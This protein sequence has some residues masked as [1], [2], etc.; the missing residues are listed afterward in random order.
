MLAWA[1]ENISLP[2]VL[3]ALL[4][5]GPLYQSLRDRVSGPG[6][7]ADGQVDG[8]D[9]DTMSGHVTRTKKGGG[10]M[11]GTWRLVDGDTF[12]D[13]SPDEDG[14]AGSSE[15][16][17]YRLYA[18]DAPELDQTCSDASGAVYACGRAALEQLAALLTAHSPISCE[19]KDNDPYGRALVVCRGQQSA[20]DTTAVD[21][22]GRMVA[23]GHAVS[24]DPMD[25]APPYQQLE[26]RA[27]SAGVGLWSG[28]F[29]MPSAYRRSHRKPNAEEY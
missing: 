11:F 29:E 6:G 17:R 14:A 19:W 20:A 15:Q 10:I 22:N 1:K 12:V 27:Q 9:V 24:Y 28:R 25:A 13:K 4:L 5:V 23:T 7:D 21:I 8:E 2:V 26:A 16:E 18:I 3:V